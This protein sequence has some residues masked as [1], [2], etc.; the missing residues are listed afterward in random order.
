MCQRVKAVHNVDSLCWNCLRKK[1]DVR[2]ITIQ[3]SGY[4]S[5][6]DGFS[7]RIQLCG[8]CYNESQKEKPIWNMD[9]VN[10]NMVHCYKYDKE[11]EHYIDSLPIVSREL[12]YN[13]YAKGASSGWKM[14]PQDWIDYES[15]LLPHEKCKEYGL[16]SPQAISAYEER[17]PKCQHPVNIIYSDGS[18]E[19]QCPNYVCGNYGQACKN[20]SI[21][22]DCYNCPYYKERTAPIIEVSADDFNDYAYY[23]LYHINKEDWEKRFGKKEAV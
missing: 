11:M 15:G 13:T 21:G 3:E 20:G 7:T 2:I 10:K 19:C 22:E 4:G 23:A 14:K 9:K 17:F 8:E 18:K 16:Y 5:S 6:F 12:V 1:D